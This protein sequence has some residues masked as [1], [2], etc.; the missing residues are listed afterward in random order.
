MTP[1]PD[2]LLAAP[3]LPRLVEELQ[4]TVAEE[5][6]ARARF[7]DTI[8]PSQKAEFIGGETIMHSPA[9]AR[10]TSV[11]K[12]LLK[13]LDTYVALHDLGWVGVE[14]SLIALTRNDYEPD[15]CFFG[16]EKAA[17]ITPDTLTFPA[18]DLAVEVLSPSTEARDR[19]IKFE[20]YALHEV[21]EYW[22]VDPIA[23]DVEQ[24]VRGADGAYVLRMKSVSG[25]L[26]S[27]AVEGF[28]VPVRA[29]FDE[30]ANL[31]ALRALL[32]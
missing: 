1:I 26:V 19:G 32:A 24:Y 31:A 6:A 28:A 21:G 16:V 27:A 23:E 11:V 8:T 29:L 14:K 17:Q 7:R 3:D 30:A 4:R 9:R 12:R 5:A 18:P 25:E 22:L 10:H 20:D 15:V 13:L 2:S